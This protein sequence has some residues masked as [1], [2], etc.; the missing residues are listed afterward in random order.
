MYGLLDDDIKNKV[1]TISKFLNKSPDDIFNGKYKDIDIKI[2][3]DNNEKTFNFIDLCCGIGGFHTAINNIKELLS[4]CILSSDIDLNC[5]KTYFINHGMVVHNDLTKIPKEKLKDVRIDM[6][7]AGFPC[8]PFSVAGKRMG[9]DDPRGTLIY[10]IFN[11]IEFLNPKFVVLENVKGLKSMTNGNNTEQKIYE[12]ILLK[13]K[14]LGYLYFDRVLSPH[15]IGIPQ[16][17]D[18]VIIVGVRSDLVQSDLHDKFQDSQLKYIE[19][20]INTKKKTET[21]IL[22]DEKEIDEQYKFTDIQKNTI[23]LWKKFV[24]MK[25]W[26]LIS[27]SEL[28]KIYS[29][30]CNKK[31][32]TTRNFKQSHIFIDFL[33]YKNN[34]NVPKNVPYYK[35]RKD[36]MISQSVYEHC[37]T[38]NLFYDNYEPFKILIDK[39]LQENITDIEKLSYVCRFLEYSGGMDYGSSCDLNKCFG[40]FRQS[41]TR[42]RKGVIF[43]TLVKSGPIPFIIKDNRFLTNVECARLQSFDDNF[44]FLSRNECMKQTGNAVNTQVIELMIR[45]VINLTDLSN[46]GEN[47]LV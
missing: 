7:C 8:Q 30:N 15:E 13:L 38:L 4:K 25:E 20:L 12:W 23:D 45:S 10:D 5:R 11:L 36:G 16:K 37:K 29:D 1:N 33:L 39:F 41:G 6:V 3:I 46:K 18:R 28:N 9:L 43:P 47:P 32:K 19:T 31:T 21:K 2:D 44:V 22:Q 24:S 35:T 34:R 17:R 14:T 42:I 40:Q 26:D 27:N